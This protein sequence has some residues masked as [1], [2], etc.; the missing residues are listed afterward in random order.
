MTSCL[1]DLAYS[2]SAYGAFPERQVHR[3]TLSPGGGDLLERLQWVGVQ[4][5]V[6]ASLG[7]DA[8]LGIAHCLKGHHLLSTSCTPAYPFP[9]VGVPKQSPSRT[10]SWIEVYTQSCGLLP[11]TESRDTY[12]DGRPAAE[13]KRPW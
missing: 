1:R 4:F 2:T 5:H 13:M 3:L 9:E 6:V 7:T 10:S 12:A 8:G 11:L